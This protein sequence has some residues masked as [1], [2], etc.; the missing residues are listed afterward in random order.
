M[1]R[2]A[3]IC[4][5]II[6]F[7]ILAATA[8]GA[9]LAA[10][11]FPVVEQT[12]DED[13]QVLEH[14]SVNVQLQ[15]TVS[16]VS[17]SDAVDL[18][19]PTKDNIYGFPVGESMYFLYAEKGSHTLS[20]FAKDHL[21]YYTA[22][23]ATYSTAIGS[24][25][26]LTPTGLF[27]ISTKEDWHRWPSGAFSPY[28][29][30]YFDTDNHYGGL[31][32]HA[33]L[34]MNTKFGTINRTSAAGVGYNV[35]GGCLRTTV[36]AA[37]FVY[38]KCPAGTQL[39]I[40]EGSPLGMTV[41]RPQTID[42]QNVLPT[43]PG[44]ALG[45]SDLDSI[46]FKKNEYS[47]EVDETIAPKIIVEPEEYSHVQLYWSC[48]NNDIVSVNDG[49]ITALSPG[50]AVVSIHTLDGKLTNS[51]TVN[52]RIREIDTDDAPPVISVIG[53]EDSDETEDSLTCETSIY[54]PSGEEIPLDAE[55]ILMYI[56]STEVLINTRVNY[57]LR[58]L[59]RTYDATKAKSC[60]YDGFD[61]NITYS[62]EGG[63]RIQIYT[64]P[65]VKGSDIICQVY[66]E[67]DCGMDIHTAA[68]VGLGDTLD[69]VVAAYGD[70]YTVQK[71]LSVNNEAGYSMVT[72]WAGETGKP[73]V[74][75]LYFTIND[76]T[77]E[78]VGIGVFSARN[79]G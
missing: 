64:I 79:L 68:G 75:Y 33:P 76:C 60:A 73:G 63:G 44:Y 31:F 16:E 32:I 26:Q 54:A 42:E 45:S 34:F 18:L 69:D 24:V 57:V 46:S 7:L 37:Y 10:R 40:V 50:T 12:P 19:N 43:L 39:M 20:V 29:T 2:S 35:T 58:D 5:W 15:K 53:N 11:L 56:D 27:E 13:T 41:D 71:T 38:E 4:S 21:G 48:N 6:C 59:G 47:I 8:Y 30:K 14:S 51:A 1:N 67:G 72:Y 22:R 52:V 74:P 36:E 28:S 70:A 61:K 25:S 78:V 55:R 9:V 49:S 3:K 77:A 23:C 62:Y 66:A 65:M 17:Y